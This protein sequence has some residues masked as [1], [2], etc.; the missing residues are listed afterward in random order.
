VFGA[1]DFGRLA[2]LLAGIAGRFILSLNDAPAVREIFAA[3]AMEEV[4]L[5]YTINDG[6]ARPAREL[7]ITPHGLPLR[8]P[9]Q[10]NLFGG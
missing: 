7:I 1:D 6:A 2:G 5:V 4:D 10:P 9:P 8:P 3:F